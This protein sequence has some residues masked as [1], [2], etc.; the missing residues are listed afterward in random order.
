MVTALSDTFCLSL[1]KNNSPFIEMEYE[2]QYIESYLLIHKFRF[3]DRLTC[4]YE[5][6]GETM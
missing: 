1:K 3:G 4:D 6:Q 5:L 2:L